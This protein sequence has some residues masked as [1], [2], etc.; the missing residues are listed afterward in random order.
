MVTGQSVVLYSPLHLILRDKTRLRFV[1]GMIIF[2]AIICHLPIIVM[3]YGAN[4]DHPEP[5]LAPYS[6]YEKVQVPIFFLQELIISVL[7]ITSRRLMGHLIYVNVII[8][9]L[10][11]TILGLEYSGLYD[12]QTA[13]KALVYS[14]K[15]KL[16][17]SIL[18]CLVELSQS[19]KSSSHTT[20]A[21]ATECAWKPSTV[22]GSSNTGSRYRAHAYAGGV[23]DG[24]A[25][26]DESVVVMTTEVIHRFED[27][28]RTD[29][30]DEL[31]F[32]SVDAKSNVTAESASE[33]P[34]DHR[35]LSSS[36]SQVKFASLGL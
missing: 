29:R 28:N 11:I 16:E 1:L 15:L 22:T 14:V 12:I 17:F 3:V 36:S 30:D 24:A 20:A 2:N 18:N 10:N 34:V 32:E 19:V 25:I 23:K 27:G 13:Y 26:Q 31:D 33:S 21:I 8:V 6:I 7:Y 5:F 4:S 35:V 9:L